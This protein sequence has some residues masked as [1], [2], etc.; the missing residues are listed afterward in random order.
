[1]YL[2]TKYRLPFSNGSLVIAIKPQ[3]NYRFRAAAILL[4]YS[5][6]NTSF[7]KSCTFFVYLLLY[8][9]QNPTLVPQPLRKFARQP[10]LWEIKTV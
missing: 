2:H 6:R 5:L 7:N 9:V 1:M 10:C 4:F 3:A 8:T